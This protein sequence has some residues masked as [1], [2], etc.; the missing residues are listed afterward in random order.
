MFSS[1]IHLQVEKIS[2]YDHCL[3]NRQDI[4]V[5]ISLKLLSDAP[6]KIMDAGLN[7]STVS[8]IID[9]NKLSRTNCHISR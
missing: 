7:I 8:N 5:H 3:L 4:V 1:F 2:V 9:S 6:L